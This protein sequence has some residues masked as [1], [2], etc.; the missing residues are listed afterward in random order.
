MMSCF[1]VQAVLWL[2]GPAGLADQPQGGGGA[3]RAFAPAFGFALAVLFALA[4]DLLLPLAPAEEPSVQ[5]C[6][7]LTQT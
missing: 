1:G 7:Q 2:S 6:L 5:E 3:T 4:F